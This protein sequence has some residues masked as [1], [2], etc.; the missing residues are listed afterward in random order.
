MSSRF[1][2]F[3]R[4]FVG[5][6][7]AILLPVSPCAASTS[8]SEDA[9]QSIVS[10]EQDEWAGKPVMTAEHVQGMVVARLHNAPRLGEKAPPFS[11]PEAAT[12]KVL[13]LAE[14][15]ADKPV[16]LYF[17]S[18]S[19]HVPHE[20]AGFFASLHERYRQV[21]NFAAVYIQEAHPEGGFEP[22]MGQERFVIPAPRSFGQRAEAALRYAVEKNLPFPM[23]VDSMDDSLAV[24]WGAWPVRI[25]VVGRDGTVL[26]AGQV[27]P[28]FFKPV[29]NYDA[30][31]FGTPRSYENL[32]GYSRESLEEFLRTLGK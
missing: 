16:V 12:G 4:A 9:A 5:G 14:L 10:P 20:T 17:L 30:N 22:A 21:A 8:D 3:R 26:Y 31:L 15:H 18:Y 1:F 27:G 24:R 6:F 19:C 13:S 7:C 23:L 2:S 25:F 28:W 29:A 32:P 11:L